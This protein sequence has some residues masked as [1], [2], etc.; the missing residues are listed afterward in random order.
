MTGLV[1][2]GITEI[3]CFQLVKGV[4]E[5]QYN[6]LLGAGASYG[7]IGGDGIALKDGATTASQINSDFKL[8]MAE[9][10]KTK[11]P[12]VYE[13]ALELD[14]I[15]LH[16]W[17]QSRFTN[18]NS[19]WQKDIFSFNWQRIW[20]FN[21]DDVLD[22]AFDESKNIEKN[23]CEQIKNF[24]W[25]DNILPIE[26]SPNIQQ[27]VYLHG[28]ASEV[29]GNKQ[30]VIFSVPEY[31]SATRSFLQWHASFQT[32]YLEKPFI[33]CGASL[34]EEVDLA[35][36]I[37]NKNESK[38]NGFP[39][40]LVSFSLTES[41]KRRMRR[42]NLIP[43]EAPLDKF[44][45]VLAIEV[46]KYKRTVDNVISS[47][48]PGTYQRFISQF[49]MLEKD[50]LSTKAVEGTDF[51]GGDEPI[52]NDILKNLDAEFSATKDAI[53]MFDSGS[54]RYAA[55]IH[56]ANVSGK[57]TSL[58]RI[59][60][61]VMSKGYNPYFFT[62]ENGLNVD[63]VLD[64]ITN[65]KRAILFID[66]ASSFLEPINRV[67]KL[68]KF[69]NTNA[70]FFISLRSNKLKGYRID[71]GKEFQCEFKLNPMKNQDVVRFVQK[72]RRVS[73]LGKHIDESDS[74][75][76]KEIKQKYK[77]DL[78]DSLCYV[79][80]SEPLRDRV[81]RLISLSNLNN[82]QKR[83]LARVVCV[84]QFGFSLPL[85]AALFSSG[86]DFGRFDDLLSNGLT[87]EGILVR[88]QRGIRLRHRILS[89]YAWIDCF[90]SDQRYKAMSEVINTLGPLINPSVI[91]SKGIEHLIIRE[92]LDERN[93]S[94]SIGNESLRFYEEQEEILGWSSRYW[95]QRALLES[96]IPG[97]FSKAYSY[98]QKAISL[99]KHPFAYTSLGTICMRHCLNLLA[100]GDVESMKWFYEGEEALS[101]AYTLSHEIMQ[102]PY[103]HPFVTFFATVKT[104]LKKIHDN[105]GE[106]IS[107]LS[108]YS[109]WVSRAEE[110]PVFHGY[111]G[112]KRLSKIKSE[113]IKAELKSRN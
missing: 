96:K 101:Q 37:R 34:D 84:H 82:D 15:K 109:F 12:L 30:G 113:Y 28:R 104:L 78:L 46:E 56:G 40:I 107:V 27:I 63:A 71:I 69:E 102:T 112:Q 98:S 39:S 13:E 6:L 58:Y 45:E 79:E 53:R 86:L 31:A 80:F 57:T 5:G 72:R 26:H 92:I 1:E 99:E 23:K 81:R 49:R 54:E 3:E 73:R 50:D 18:C 94:K 60:R 95:D 10:E 77:A 24:N 9:G 32:H 64:F 42:Y 4:F 85:R 67:L 29:G 17:L 7:C 48:K 66:N 33:V 90:S 111:H 2:L 91:S 44:F 70:R 75:I 11:L 61:H 97:H 62:H 21:I 74:K 110:S 51:Y 14:S 108:I 8:D 36:A 52:W 22:N 105:T 68:A 16:K 76:I 35:E 25:K 89:E 41:Q 47:L 83:L 103:E 55:L 59:A 19:T 43:I 65:D 20:T 106:Y 38:A 87:T 100:K 88:D 93:V